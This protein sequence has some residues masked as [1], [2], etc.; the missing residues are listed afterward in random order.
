MRCCRQK[1][2]KMVNI[3]KLDWQRSK[4]TV[5]SPLF[6]RKIAE[7]ELFALRVAI[8]DESQNYLGSGG[9]IFDTHSRWL[10]VKQSARYRRCYGKIGDCTCEQSKMKV[11]VFRWELP[12][13]LRKSPVKVTVIVESKATTKAMATLRKRNLK[14]NSS[15]F[16]LY[17]AY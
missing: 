2:R 3:A 10:A 16:K 12:W 8:L 7:I 1:Y 13:Q 15:C 17:H 9:G 5:H 6:F 14:V 11:L 4:Y